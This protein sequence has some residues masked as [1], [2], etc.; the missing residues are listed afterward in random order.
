MAQVAL[1][2]TERGSGQP[3]VLVP[4]GW[5]LASDY[6]DPLVG[7]LAAEARVIQFDPRGC[8]R[9]ESRPPYDLATMLSDLDVVR[10][11][12]GVDRWVV[13]GHSAGATQALA[14]GIEY[15]NQVS[16]VVCIA[17]GSG[18]HDDRQWHAAYEAGRDAGLDTAP[19]TR[20]PFNL[21]LNRTLNE[22]WRRYIKH[23]RLPRRMADFPVP[24]LVVHGEKDIRP[25][26]P[27]EQIAELVSDG[28]FVVVQGAG[29]IPWTSHGAEVSALLS[30]FLRGVN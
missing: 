10:V 7:M 21:E 13:V 2:W 8:G 27:M 16:G 14:Y 11:Q 17:G 12:A 28:K 1:W 26:W 15:P 24:L 3:V 9:S 29:H 18:L 25:S 20:F 22:S 6:L 5:G 4:G 30:Q 23:P 19:D